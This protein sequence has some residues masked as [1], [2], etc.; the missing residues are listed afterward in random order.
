MAKPMHVR[1]EVGKEEAEQIYQLVEKARDTGKL[2]RG[3]NEVTKAIERSSAK[4]VIMAEDV[5]PPE[6]LVHIPALCD[7]KSIS[8]SYVPSKAEL[9]SAAGLSVPTSAISID[10]IG[11][12]SDIVARIDRWKDMVK[13]ERPV[14]KEPKGELTKRVT[15][16]P[17]KRPE[18]KPERKPERRP[19]R[20]PE[21]RPEK[22]PERRPEKKPERRP[23]KAEERP[24][25]AEERPEKA[26]ERPEKAKEE[27]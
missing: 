16:T 21:R 18:R 13:K 11:E 4:F 10:D 25:K 8:Y 6:L 23:E 9:G 26:E 5:D 15:K 1:F 7:E 2:R 20:K 17:V 27:V 12:A 22:K 3:T 24:E 19:E 14:V